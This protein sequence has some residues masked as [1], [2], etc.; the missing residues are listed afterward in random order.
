MIDRGRHSVLGVM[1]DAVDQEAAVERIITAAIASRSLSAT[2]LAVHGV[3]T[4]VL[5]PV[6]RRR[7]NRFDLVVPDG[8]P[9]RWAL[10]WMYSTHLVERVY[11]PDLMLG[12]C[13]RAQREALSIFLFGSRPE[14]L[15]PLQ[16]RLQTQFPRLS[17]A[18]AEPSAFRRGTG[19]E[20]SRR[21]QQIRESGAH[22]VF[23]GLGCPR[24]EI[25]TYEAREALSMPVVSVGA[26]FDFHAG[27]LAQAPR[28]L[29][30]RGLEW[31]YRLLREP[32]R[33]W[34]RYLLLNPAF[35]ALLLLEM[36]R[37]HSIAPTREPPPPKTEHPG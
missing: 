13:D 2:A 34:R 35:L 21:W 16:I 4:G 8:Q 30:R 6:H 26:A 17:I 28:W 37:I 33:L 11:G 32:R 14:V 27:A 15:T 31:T 23:V 9:V 29:Q 18:G 5:D 22:I 20:A 1:V 3:M 12:V 19:A 10:N 25:W 36:A 24:Q 7:L